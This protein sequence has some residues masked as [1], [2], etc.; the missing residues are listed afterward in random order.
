MARYLLALGDYHFCL[1]H[2]PGVQNHADALSQCP[3]FDD[4]EHDNENVIVL[5]DTLFIN[6]LH[7]VD[8]EQQCREVQDSHLEQLQ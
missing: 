6:V 2:K 7:T 8:L 1:I 4:G 3:D 5:P